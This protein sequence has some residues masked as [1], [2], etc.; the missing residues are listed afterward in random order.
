M[1]LVFSCS[2]HGFIHVPMLEMDLDIITQN[3]AI[4]H[5]WRIDMVNLLD[6]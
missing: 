3:F 5:P 1:P 4:Q 2:I 6:D